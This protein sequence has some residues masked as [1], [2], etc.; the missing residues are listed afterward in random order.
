MPVP[1]SPHFA[2][3]RGY[4]GCEA[5]PPDIRNKVHPDE[6]SDLSHNPEVLFLAESPADGVLSSTTDPESDDTEHGQWLTN[7]TAAKYLWLVRPDDVK[8]ALEYGTLGQETQRGRLAHT[9]L[10][11]NAV[12]HAGGEL[13]FKNAESVYIN[14]GSSRF[15]PRSPEEWDCLVQSFKAAGYRVCSFGWDADKGAPKRTLRRADIVWL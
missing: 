14:G 9:N 12:A 2:A 3:Y 13:W 10:S 15:Q 4:S 1:A 8:I 5:R 7:D 11:G 6:T